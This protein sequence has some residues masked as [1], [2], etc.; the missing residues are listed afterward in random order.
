MLPRTCVTHR[1]AETELTQASSAKTS[2]LSV[3]FFIP[4]REHQKSLPNMC[5]AY[6]PVSPRMPGAAPGCIVTAD[7]LPDPHLAKVRMSDVGE[8]PKLS[9]HFGCSCNV[10]AAC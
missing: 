7:R 10:L 5:S 8:T 3:G 6:I 1:E 4:G 2:F 9:V